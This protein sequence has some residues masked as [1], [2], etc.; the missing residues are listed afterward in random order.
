MCNLYRTR[1]GRSE[2]VAASRA[3]HADVGNLE[4]GDI[5]PD[6]LPPSSATAPKA[7]R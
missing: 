3:M 4:P 7:E 6:Y 2:L 5:Y 1:S